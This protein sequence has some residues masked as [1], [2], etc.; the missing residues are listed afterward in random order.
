MEEQAMKRVAAVA[1]LVALGL[2]FSGSVSAQEK[3]AEVRDA[4]P[5]VSVKVSVVVSE[6]EGTKKV[7][8]L[9][10]AFYV[11]SDDTTPNGQRT[12]QVRVGIR[13]PIRTGGTASAS[14]FQYMD[15]GTNLDCRVTSQTDGR[16]LLALSIERSYLYNT[17]G[18]EKNPN[19]AVPYGVPISNENP[20]IAHFNSSYDLQIRDGQTIEA[21]STTDP[22]SG[23]VLK[24]E[25]TANVVK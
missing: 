24:I 7:A 1:V 12:S 14:Q 22:V 5:I 9:P 13:V 3:P 6:L 16:Y 21:T 20:I 23:R 15:I 19:A 18:N 10:Y 25:V 4:K 2:V 17:S 8:S 11:N